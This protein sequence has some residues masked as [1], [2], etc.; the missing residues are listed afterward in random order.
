MITNMLSLPFSDI[1]HP[2]IFQPQGIFPHLSYTSLLNVV[3]GFA[4]LLDVL[5][6]HGCLS[7]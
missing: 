5:A 4:A 1:L 6:H 7:Y 3:S 2:L